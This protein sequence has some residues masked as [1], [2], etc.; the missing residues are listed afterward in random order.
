[1][2]ETS[3]LIRVDPAWFALV[4]T[5]LGEKD[6]AFEWLNKG[7]T[8]RPSTVIRMKIEPR[9]EPLHSDPRFAQLIRRMGL[10]E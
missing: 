7:Y 4:Y 3:K 6:Q 10:P 2:R 9:F 5:G 8:D 1:M